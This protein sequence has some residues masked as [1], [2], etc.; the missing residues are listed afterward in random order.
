[1]KASARVWKAVLGGGLLLI[2]LYFAL[3]SAPQNL[4]YSTIGLLS[5][6]GI[7]VG[8]HLFRPADRLSWYLLAAGGV[9]FTLGDDV[10][11]LYQVVLHGSVP[12]PSIADAFYLAGYPF[13]FAAILRLTRSPD[14][15]VRREDY[16]DAAIVSLGV[17]ALAWHFLMSPEVH[18]ASLSFVGMLV[19]LA[20]PIMDVALV[21]IVFR[22]LL[23]GSSRRP[24]HTILAAALLTMLLSDF[25]YDLLVLH[26]AYS[27][28]NPVDALF[29]LEYLLVAVA[30]LHPSM[31]WPPE[32][33]PHEA[34]PAHRES[35]TTRRMPV[36]AL[37]GLVPP[38]ILLI[39]SAA[40]IAVDVTVL[41]ALCI[42]VSALVY[43][44]MSWMIA[45]MRS[46]AQEIGQ[47]VEAL[48]A[49][50]LK[51]D[52]LEAD[53]RHQ[54][55]H[56]ELTGLANR[57]LLH[58]RIDRAL[59]SV[60]RSGH[61]VALCFGDLDGFKT[62]NDTLGHHMGDG[63]LL[64]A[65]Q[66]LASIVR[67]GDTV[68][69]LGGDEFAVLM[70]DVEHPETAVS[71]ARR[72]VSVMRDSIEIA[73]STVN[74]SISMG[75]AFADTTKSTEQLLSEADSAMYEAKG[76]GKDCVQVFQSSMRSRMLERLEL[77]NGFRGSL[78]R[79]EFFLQYQPIYRLVDHR[80]IGFEALVR[81]QHPTLGQVAPLRFVPVAEETGF[82]VPL[83][84]WILLEACE[85]QSRLCSLTEAPLA[86]SVNLSRRQLTSPSLV[87]DLQTALSLSAVDADRLIL[88]IT[89]SVLMDDP[90]RAGDALREL[91]ALGAHIAVD[92]FGTGYS[93]L[94]HLQRFPVDVLKI[95]KSFIDPLC[96]AEG[97]TTA[98]VTTILGLAGNLGL[99]VIAEGIEHDEQLRRLVELDCELGQGYLLGHPLDAAD[100][101]SL[102]RAAG[103]VR[104]P[105]HTPS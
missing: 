6:V 38:L 66:L 51:R 13:V 46:Q 72:I 54:A 21:F 76:H 3:P 7:L 53:L 99:R 44:R 60:S 24:Y 23:F 95:D 104:H 87:K 50:H 15:R 86:M 37:A 1:M 10:E 55:F 58:E 19:T 89:E 77:T 103:G 33:A 74:L 34:G 73:G 14:H 26:N 22:S 97:D 78:E 43:L 68:A 2:A 101:R 70:V 75:L 12:T 39:A 29:L 5:V 41:A 57:A 85:E 18:D 94:S 52:A 36:I 96:D 84:R 100:A 32:T 9:C 20:Y 59:A 17:L 90:E 82:I 45:R 83:G 31:S 40:G 102:V 4:L 92:D 42:A 30:A 65:G 49:S 79:G 47:Q 63:V 93:S 11:T 16:A 91:K 69:R 105:S 62:V 67:P 88:E 61:S 64:K 25:V 80:L 81:W 8:V 98:L 56:D 35:V 27:D 71:F 48:E 28:G